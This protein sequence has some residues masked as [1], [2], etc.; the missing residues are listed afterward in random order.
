MPCTP[1]FL[2][3]PYRPSSSDCANGAMR[4]NRPHHRFAP[5]ARC[6]KNR[7][8]AV[9]YVSTGL[10][11]LPRDTN[12]IRNYRRRA[13]VYVTP[14]PANNLYNRSSAVD[15]SFHNQ[16]QGR[17]ANLGLQLYNRPS[18]VASPIKKTPI[19]IGLRQRR[20]A[21]KNAEERFNTLARGWLAYPVTP[22]HAHLPPK[23]GCRNLFP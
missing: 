2:F 3:P 16:P 13:V 15:S 22:T 1:L 8:R 4:K 11:C 17:Q 18:A 5:T 7:R 19:I 12:N 9:S 14:R 21:K 20:N 23:S 10:A 6:E